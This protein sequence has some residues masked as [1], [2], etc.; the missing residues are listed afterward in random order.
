M[1]GTPC[2]ESRLRFHAR[3]PDRPAPGP[4][5]RSH[6]TYSP[7]RV[8][9]VRLGESAENVLAGQPRSFC[10]FAGVLRRP[11]GAFSRG[12]GSRSPLSAD[13]PGCQPVVGGSGGRLCCCGRFWSFS[14][15]MPKYRVVA[16]L[17]V[18]M[19]VRL[20]LRA[21]G[22]TPWPGPVPAGG[23]CPDGGHASRPGSLPCVE[24]GGC[25][26]VAP[27]LVASRRLLVCYVAHYNIV[28]WDAA[29][30]EL[31]TQVLGDMTGSGAWSEDRM[32]KTCSAVVA[33][34]MSGPEMPGSIQAGGINYLE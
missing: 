12:S 18:R 16:D 4:G 10:V 20:V 26:D 21:A 14:L 27:R 25:S 24:I 28:Q 5:G 34:G 31:P 11:A 23:E 6:F 22:G 8:I 13:R 7:Y 1:S 3:C 19:R 17:P 30:W 15:P 29:V 32:T 9:A 33:S 2:L